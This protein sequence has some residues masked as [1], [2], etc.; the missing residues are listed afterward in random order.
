MSPTHC[1]W[2]M[3]GAAT[4]D[5]APASRPTARVPRP[6]PRPGS[7]LGA[8]APRSR[9]GPAQADTEAQ[10]FSPGGWTLSAT[11]VPPCRVKTAARSKP[12]LSQS[13]RV[14]AQKSACDRDRAAEAPERPAHSEQGG[15]VA[16][17]PAPRA[18]SPRP[19][20]GSGGAGLGGAIGRRVGGEHRPGRGSDRVGRE[21]C[22]AHQAE[23]RT[24]ATCPGS[25]AGDG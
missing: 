21:Q 24:R 14:A 11:S 6:R 23:P 19:R 4:K 7:P 18:R 20:F 1:S 12:A 5:S 25:R 10:P 2:Q 22:R 9:A 8:A 16:A 17:V 15:S 3:I 13:A